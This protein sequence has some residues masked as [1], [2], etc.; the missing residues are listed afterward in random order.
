MIKPL[1]VT[2]HFGQLNTFLLLLLAYL[3]FYY[4]DG[5][6]HARSSVSQ[7]PRI[8]KCLE[9]LDHR[10]V[11]L[12]EDQVNM[13]YSS[14]ADDAWTAAQSSRSDGHDHNGSLGFALIQIVNQKLFITVPNGVKAE[15]HR[16]VALL[17]VL[18][19]I[20]KSFQMPDVQFLLNFWDR[21]LFTSRHDI[22][23]L[24][25]TGSEASLDF[26]FPQYS[27]LTYCVWAE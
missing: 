16:L 2:V 4:K 11:R 26:L 22:P 20:L 13:T 3:V 24:S 18:L 7:A 14:M 15:N 27:R 21:P 8:T 25:F 12:V 10:L 23:L 17:D 9:L 1:I 5:H 19:G 6:S